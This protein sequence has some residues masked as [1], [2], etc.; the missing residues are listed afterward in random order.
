MR[1]WFFRRQ[2]AIDSAG[3]DEEDVDELAL[4]EHKEIMSRITLK[5]E[6][7]Q[8]LLSL[9]TVFRNLWQQNCA[10]APAYKAHFIL[11]VQLRVKVAMSHSHVK[12]EPEKH[13]Q[14]PWLPS[15]GQSAELKLIS[16]LL[17]PPP[18]PSSS[19]FVLC[20]AVWYTDVWKCC[21]PLCKVRGG[22]TA[23][24]LKRRRGE[25]RNVRRKGL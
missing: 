20:G 14:Q 4:I 23:M 9:S 18:P 11:L 2:K 12:S 13:H 10:A 24:I 21:L 8:Q 19:S 3:S 16:P 22:V 17:P 5:Q 1:A 15:G 6:V 25:V 7:R